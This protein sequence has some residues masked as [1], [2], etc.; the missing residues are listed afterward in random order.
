MLLML[1]YPQSFALSYPRSYPRELPARATRALAFF[2]RRTSLEAD[3]SKQPGEPA[4]RLCFY[5]GP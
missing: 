2:A 5:T 1:S 4:L 3:N